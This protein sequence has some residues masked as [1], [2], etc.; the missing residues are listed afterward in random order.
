MTTLKG[1]VYRVYFSLSFTPAGSYA[2]AI[3]PTV[4]AAPQSLTLL[5]NVKS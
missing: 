3:V 1:F 4:V 2:E 5:L